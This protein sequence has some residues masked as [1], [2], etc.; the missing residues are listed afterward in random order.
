MAEDAIK[1]PECGKAVAGAEIILDAQRQKKKKQRNIIITIVVCIV[2]IVGIAVLCSIKKSNK[3][4]ADSYIQVIDMNISA[5]LENNP[6]KYLKSYPD[7][8]RDTIEE[9]L[10]MLADD[11]FDE[12]I[13]LLHDEIVSVYGSDAVASYDT[14][15]KEH[16][17]DEDAQEYLESIFELIDDYDIEDFPIEDAYQLTLE[18]VINGSVGTQTFYPTIAVMEFDGSWYLLNIINPI[19]SSVDDQQG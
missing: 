11:N 13:D 2:L 1:C 4:G 19:N 15:S 5:M 6:S 9:T 16:L 18:V 17:S 12:Y 8:M 14:Y 7:F 10:G 3:T